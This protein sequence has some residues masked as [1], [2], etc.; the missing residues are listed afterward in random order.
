MKVELSDNCPPAN[1]MDSDGMSITASIANARNS[2]RNIK[3]SGYKSHIT[4][5]YS[6]F[7]I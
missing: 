2:K 3:C 6:A 7:D 1:L 5:V 4:M